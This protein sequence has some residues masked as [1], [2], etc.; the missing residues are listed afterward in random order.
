[1]KEEKTSIFKIE[2]LIFL[3]VVVYFSF[4]KEFVM[5]SIGSLSER[6]GRKDLRVSTKV[7]LMK[8]MG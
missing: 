5:K 8:F 7:S 2:F 3:L 6:I 4:F 1:M